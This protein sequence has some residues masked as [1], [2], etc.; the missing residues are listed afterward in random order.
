SRGRKF[1]AWLTGYLVVL[2][3]VPAAA[4]LAIG[5]LGPAQFGA[6]QVPHW[7][8]EESRPD[9]GPAVVSAMLSHEGLQTE[10]PGRS[11]E[12]RS[13]LANVRSQPRM[14]RLEGNIVLRGPIPRRIR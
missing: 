11:D 10:H 1:A 4:V 3:T 6:P 8:S 12:I 5:Q 7:L 2:L 9:D 13:M 14:V